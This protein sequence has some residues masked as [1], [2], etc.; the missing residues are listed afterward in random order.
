MNNSILIKNA[1]FSL[2]KID[3][4]NIVKLEITNE[5]GSFWTLSDGEP[6]LVDTIPSWMQPANVVTETAHSGEIEF[7]E[8]TI[9][10]F[11]ISSWITTTANLTAFLNGT[12]HQDRLP[13][14][15]NFFYGY[16]A[17]DVNAWGGTGNA[18]RFT[19]WAHRPEILK[20]MNNIYDDGEYS[21]VKT[22][23]AYF[24]IQF[25]HDDYTK[26]LF[27]WIPDTAP[28]AGAVG[29]AVP[30]LYAVVR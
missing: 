2:S 23:G 28:V 25:T 18:I 20:Y 16:R 22:S 7:P 4:L 26:G 12:G 29:I 27:N 3:K 21:A 9:A 19:D 8:G 11:G 13:T 15:T 10:I 30:E 5:G 24:G 14:K 17:G 6:T 1:D